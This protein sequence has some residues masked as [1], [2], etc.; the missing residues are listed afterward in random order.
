[1]CMGFRTNLIIIFSAALTLSSNVLSQE[2]EALPPLPRAMAV[3]GDS[4][5]EGMLAD[6]SIER[7][8]T[9]SQLLHMFSL[10]SEGGMEGVREVYASK[11]KSWATGFDPDDIVFS[12][13][14]RLQQL[15]PEIEGFNFA[16]SGAR[17]QDLEEQLTRFFEKEEELGYSIDYV[18]IM[19][20][21]NDLGGLTLEDVL[22]PLEYIGGLE[23]RIRDIL[24]SDPNRRFV[25]MGLPNIF[26]VFDE[27]A[28]VD[29]YNFLGMSISCEKMRSIIYGK[30]AMFYRD[31]EDVD[32]ALNQ[33]FDAYHGGMREMLYRLGKE[34]PEAD[35]KP[36]QYYDIVQNPKKALSIDCFH[37]S[38]WGQAEIAESS[39]FLGFWG[40]LE[41]DDGL[42]IDF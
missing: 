18:V 21:A 2:R 27:T 20:G 11:K 31:V 40:D 10:F 5:S 7:P 24:E 3:L 15:D 26:W 12:H 36:I 23:A 17:V 25:V 41:I 22:S 39:W 29:T 16:V 33:T 1:M 4:F 34:Y 35:F 30:R 13:L 42:A 6:F 14:E 38:P 37:P 19:I 9:V 28:S 32:D 8:P